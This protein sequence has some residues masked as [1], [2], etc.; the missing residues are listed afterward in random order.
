MTAI[1]KLSP[2]QIAKHANFSL[3]TVVTYLI[4]NFRENSF[5]SYFV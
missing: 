1:H 2:W 3:R 4:E 5:Y